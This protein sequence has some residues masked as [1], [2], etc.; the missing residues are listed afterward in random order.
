MIKAVSRCGIDFARGV[1]F[2]GQ[3]R[4]L[5]WDRFFHSVRVWPI[6]DI[7]RLSNAHR[8]TWFILSLI[9]P[10]PYLVGA[11]LWLGY[12]LITFNGKASRQRLLLLI[13]PAVLFAIGLVFLWIAMAK[14]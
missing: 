1:D 6:A 4:C 8:V 7:E 2:A 10:G 9:A 3:E 13:G 11:M 14:H 5:V 12:M